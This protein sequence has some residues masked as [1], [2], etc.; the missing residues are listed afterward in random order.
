MDVENILNMALRLGAEEVIAKRT[1]KDDLQVRFSQNRV[2]ILNNWISE[3]TNVFIA[4]DG[5]TTGVEI[6]DEKFAEKE[7]E[8]AME[9][10][11]K[12]PKNPDFRGIYD[13]K[14]KSSSGL[15]LKDIDVSEMA[16][17]A[18]NSALAHDVKRVSGEIYL[19]RH[20]VEVCTRYNHLEELRTYLLS[21]VRAFNSEG[22]P[23]QASTHV[24]SMADMLN[25]GP[26]FVGDKAGR[27][28]SMNTRVKDGEEGEFTV[29]FDPLTFGS[30]L[31]S[32][33]R[34]L[35]AFSVDTGTSF[36][37][38]MLE[39]KVASE[40][41]TIYDDPTRPGRGQASFDDEGAPTRKTEAI[42]K[43]V[44]KTYLHSVSTAKKFGTETTGN[45]RDAGK[46]SS[47]NPSYWQLSV[48]PGK[49]KM[50][51]LMGEIKDGLYIANTWYT[52]YQ[53]YRKGDFSTIPRDGIF[54]IK[55]G[56]I[57]ES[58]KGIRISDNMLRIAKNL[59]ELSSD[60]IPADWWG[61]TSS[62]F[63]P[64]ALVEGVRITKSH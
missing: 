53:D 30:I 12:L 44:L 39:K 1:V 56:E 38:D 49:R 58:W 55:D 26:E 36:F 63:S 3:S 28:A 5:R 40:A 7:L 23:G 57:V 60:T 41:L 47:I 4:V 52:R 17:V 51:A 32:V 50:E 31:S 9:F 42:S 33:G 37:T 19:A 10:A 2:D 43:G 15:D 25:Y 20:R 24:G 54:R 34:S 29:L 46:M 6:K 35:S 64:Y 18:I 21:T 61:E 11:K 16:D 13:R 8:K 22:N 48:E 14:T 59:L 45:G 62:V 27:I